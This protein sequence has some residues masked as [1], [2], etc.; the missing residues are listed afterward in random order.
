MN[1]TRRRTNRVAGPPDD[2]VLEHSQREVFGWSLFIER[3]R[4]RIE[5]QRGR[6]SGGIAAEQYAA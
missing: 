4:H 2:F 5:V 3:H 1:S 6:P